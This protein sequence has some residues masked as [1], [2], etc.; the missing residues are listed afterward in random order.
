MEI[1]GEKK[2]R[3]SMQNLFNR[4]QQRSWRSKSSTGREKKAGKKGDIGERN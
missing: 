4:T 2:T 3:K 1:G